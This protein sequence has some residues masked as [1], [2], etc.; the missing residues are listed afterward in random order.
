MIYNSAI[1][2]YIVSRFQDD[3]IRFEY[4]IISGMENNIQKCPSPY[5]D[6]KHIH[7]FV[8]QSWKA[9]ITC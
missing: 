4:K 3:T 8:E 1:Y 6:V 7:V 5:I 9:N 2:S